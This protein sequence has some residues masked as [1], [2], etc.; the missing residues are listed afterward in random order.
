MDQLARVHR[1]E[2]VAAEAVRQHK[3]RVLL[4]HARRFQLVVNPEQ[5]PDRLVKQCLRLRRRKLRRN[6]ARAGKVD[7]A[8]RLDRERS[9]A[10]FNQKL[11]G[12]YRHV[13]E[14][15]IDVAVFQNGRVPRGQDLS[16]QLFIFLFSG[17]KRF[18]ADFIRCAVH[19]GNSAAGGNHRLHVRR[20]A[21]KGNVSVH[22]SLLL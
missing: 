19:G 10:E 2:E 11:L 14:R 16:D 6:I 12:K 1:A 17:G 9:K 21:Q 20:P 5:F 4:R 15:Q 7:I 3:P 18:C 13:L 22:T 8:A